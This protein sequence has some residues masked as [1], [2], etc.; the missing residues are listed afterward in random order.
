MKVKTDLDALRKAGLPGL[1]ARYTTKNSMLRS[2]RDLTRPKRPVSHALTL[3]T[4]N[5]VIIRSTKYRDA[6]QKTGLP[7]LDAC[8]TKNSKSTSKATLTRPEKAGLSGLDACHT[9]NS[10]LSST[11]DLHPPPKTCVPGLKARHTKTS[12]I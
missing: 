12:I 7:G 2:R 5:V 11:R 8:H 4:R 6:P 1:D 3:A 10:T 9:K